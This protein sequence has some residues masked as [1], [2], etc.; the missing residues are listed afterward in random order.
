[1]KKTCAPN[2]AN[3]PPH[4]REKPIEPEE[5]FLRRIAQEHRRAERSRQRFVLVLIQGFAALPAETAAITAPIASAIREIDTW[6]WYESQAT[7]GILFTELG[8]A[9]SENARETIVDKIQLALPRAGD[10]ET[11]AVSAYI[12]PRDFDQK[13]AFGE[14][15]ERICDYPEEPLSSPDVK[16]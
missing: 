10:A 5:E 8:G 2:R 16:V 14:A 1:M 3:L 13:A 12:L 4:G 9:D 15:L 11:L 6:G 7:L